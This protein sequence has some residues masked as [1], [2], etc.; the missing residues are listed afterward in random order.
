MTPQDLRER[1]AALKHD[2][3]KY[4]A[5]T[6]VNLDEAVWEGP[7]GDELTSALRRDLLAT[8]TRDG[9][10][11]PAWA[12]WARLTDGIDE[13]S[14]IAELSA[15]QAAVKVL[16]AAGPGLAV[17]D[18]TDVLARRGQIRDAQLLIR[19]QLRELTRRLAREA[20]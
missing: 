6:S 8:L 5:W 17:D 7:L 20:D 10:A 19:E 9:Q 4:V 13:V 18:R 11:E 15:V 16:E 2:L 12:V 3:G 14:E 1:V